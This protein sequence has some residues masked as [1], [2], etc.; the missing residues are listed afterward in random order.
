[1]NVDA[2]DLEL[3]E[4]LAVG[5]EAEAETLAEDADVVTLD[6][7]VVATL[8]VAAAV[9]LGGAARLLV[10][11]MELRDSMDRVKE[12]QLMFSLVLTCLQ[13]L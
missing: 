5:A 9:A 12:L 6:A 11:V 1:M 13:T 8:G 2:V 4:A 7:V 3:G 10:K